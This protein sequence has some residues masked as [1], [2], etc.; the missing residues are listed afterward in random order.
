MSQLSQN[1][2]FIYAVLNQTAHPAPSRWQAFTDWIP[3]GESDYPDTPF[4]LQTVPVLYVLRSEVKN[5]TTSATSTRTPPSNTCTRQH[6][7]NIDQR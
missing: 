1:S 6:I 5:F 7:K 2:R 3:N 4:T